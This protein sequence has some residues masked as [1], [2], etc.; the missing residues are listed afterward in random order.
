MVLFPNI[1]VNLGLDILRKRPD[2]YHDIATVMIGVDWCDV[3][4]VIKAPDGTD[5]LYTSGLWVDCP[6]EKNLVMKALKGVRERFGD[7]IGTVHIYLQ[8]NVPDGAGLGGGSSDAAFMIKAINTLFDLKMPDTEMAEIA[9]GIG[10]DC[11]YFIYNTPMLATGRGEL[12]APVAG[13]SD[14]LTDY[15]IVIVKAD[16]VAVSTAAAYAGITP[17][18]KEV[19]PELIIK[20]PVDQWKDALVNDFEPS[21]FSKTER[22]EAIKKQLYLMGAVYAS[23][24]GSGSAVFGIFKPDVIEAIDF[25]AIFPECA[26]HVG[27]FLTE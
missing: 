5:R 2:G 9:A 26:I 18:L 15:K 3:L 19:S 4:E 17:A 7:K 25:S 8:K 13:L 22:P 11:P 20:R 16:D 27:E 12:L 1:K 14:V 6:P 10:C 21:I 24:S 23:M